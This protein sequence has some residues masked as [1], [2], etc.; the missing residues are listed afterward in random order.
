MNQFTRPDGFV[1][2]VIK[3]NRSD[4]WRV[5]RRLQELEISCWCPQDGTLWVEING[6]VDAILLRSTVQQFAS[7]RYELAS[8]LERCWETSNFM[9][10]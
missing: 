9:P 6:W 10:I 3:I 4:R 8:W 7:S 5:S 2:L 1:S